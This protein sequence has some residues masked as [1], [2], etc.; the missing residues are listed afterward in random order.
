MAQNGSGT[1]IVPEGISLP[2]KS[3]REQLSEKQ[4]RRIEQAQEALRSA[5]VTHETLKGKS[6]K[7]VA[8]IVNRVF[9]ETGLGL[10]PLEKD[11]DVLDQGSLV[12]AALNKAGLSVS[13]VYDLVNSSEPYPHAIPI[14][15]R[16]LPEISAPE[17][18]EGIVRALTVKEARGIAAGP[19]IEEF[20]RA[21]LETE[22]GLKW[23]IGNA[24]E[25]VADDTDFE[26]IAEL[27]QDRR[28]GRSRQMMVEALGKMKS[29]QAED[30]LISLLQDDEVAGHAI[31]ALG[32]LRSEKARPF[33]E[34]F[35]DHPRGWIQT[36]ARR[37]LSRI[38]KPTRRRGGHR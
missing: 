22:S 24:L 34:P 30:I 21:P 38:D 15:V 2:K 16:M 33:I 20:R 25:T 19:L 17:I 29:P 27:V 5:G 28:H 31:V 3:P 6:G 9:R 35:L 8:R 23:A 14:L 1:A 18:K 26:A 13:S 11:P 4:R 10:P 7:E 37:A 32:K 36:A 12:A